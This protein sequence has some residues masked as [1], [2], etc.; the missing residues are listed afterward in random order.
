MMRC[1]V[2]VSRLYPHEPGVLRRSF[3][4]LHA[5]NIILELFKENPYDL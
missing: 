2:F 1:I 4:K 3:G 5:G